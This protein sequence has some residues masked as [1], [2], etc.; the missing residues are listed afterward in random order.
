MSCLRVYRLTVV[1]IRDHSLYLLGAMN[2]SRP[3][4][5]GLTKAQDFR[6]ATQIIKAG[7]YATD[8]RYV[9]KICDIIRRYGLDKYD[10]ESGGSGADAVVVKES[11]ISATVVEP[12]VA[13]VAEAAGKKQYV[14]Q[15]GAFSVK[16][17][18]RKRLREVRKLGGAFKKAFMVKAGGQYKVQTGVFAD[19]RNA[20]RMAQRLEKAGISTFIKER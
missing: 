12:A 9:D 8:V 15:A 14:V 7:G 18:A 19:R 2:G 17:N 4:Y 5:A 16:G 10:R 11:E 3:R 6:E 13:L 1:S 20:E